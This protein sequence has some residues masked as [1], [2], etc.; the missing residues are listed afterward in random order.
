MN[1]LSRA[2]I[3]LAKAVTSPSTVTGAKPTPMLRAVV[4]SATPL[5]VRVGI[6]ETPTPAVNT[7]TGYTPAPGDVVVVSRVGR[8]QFIVGKI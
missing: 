6:A 1:E 4:T 5:L 2:F 8:R 3:D 7:D